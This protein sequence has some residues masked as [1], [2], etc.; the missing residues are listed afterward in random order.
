MSACNLMNVF[1]EEVLQCFIEII[2]SFF[3]LDVHIYSIQIRTILFI[4]LSVSPS[5][6]CFGGTSSLNCCNPTTQPCSSSI[7][8]CAAPRYPFVAPPSTYAVAGGSYASPPAGG[9]SNVGPISGP[10]NGIYGSPAD[11]YS[12]S[13]D[14]PIDVH[15]ELS[16]S[17]PA[18]QE[19]AS[20][21]A[22]VQTAQSNY[23]Q[24]TAE[25]GSYPTH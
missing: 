6:A 16:S 12:S 22:H 17:Y 19:A 7:P 25:A 18:P 13:H 15:V 24:A 9:P 20:A 2:Q 11:S 3:L 23:Q 4:I 5:M 1:R 21:Q 10:T 14:A 8:P